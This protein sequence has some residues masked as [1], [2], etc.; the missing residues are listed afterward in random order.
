MRTPATESYI[1]PVLTTEVL[2][3]TVRV[4]SISCGWHHHYDFLSVEGP[5]FVGSVV[6]M[7][8][9]KSHVPLEWRFKCL[10]AS[11]VSFD[12]LDIYPGSVLSPILQVSLE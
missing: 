9:H 8:S 11:L 4:H 7:Q 12:S 1:S 5:W 3:V 2:C 10:V 6:L